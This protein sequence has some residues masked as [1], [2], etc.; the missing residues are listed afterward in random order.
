M[1]YIA[2]ASGQVLEV[3]FGAVIVCGGR[4]CTEYTGEVPDGYD[5]LIDW[6]TAEGDKL[7]RWQIVNGNLQRI[8]NA[9][10]PE[11][12]TPF[13]L[14][15]VWENKTPA[16]TFGEQTIGPAFASGEMA[17]VVFAEG[18][19]AATRC[20]V[21]VRY[22]ENSRMLGMYG[23]TLTHRRVKVKKEGVTVYA[24]NRMLT[25]G[26]WT[27]EDKVLVPVALYKV[28]GIVEP[29]NVSEIRAI[30]GDFMCGEVVAGQ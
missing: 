26:T 24:G 11:V 8:E 20:S 13:G 4:K 22:G 14:S 2:N 28:T 23:N 15:K 30:C 27:P 5:S 21:L 16:E 29:T 25:Y 17:L 3:S 1:R 19:D 12:F 18:V 7:H 10:E 9:A 6:F